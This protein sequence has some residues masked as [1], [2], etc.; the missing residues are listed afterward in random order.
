M[1]RPNLKSNFRF[2]KRFAEDFKKI[3][4][5]TQTEV[6]DVFNQYFPEC[7]SISDRLS[8]AV[9][10]FTESK[11][12]T[13]SKNN[14]RLDLRALP[15]ITHLLYNYNN[16]DKERF[17]LHDPALSI[18][19]VKACCFHYFFQRSLFSNGEKNKFYKRTYEQK[20]SALYLV[21]NAFHALSM[22]GGMEFVE[23]EF[24]FVMSMELEDL[25]KND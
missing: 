14:G 23:K 17:L 24:D 9:S 18:L 25:D 19:L 6:S 4:A 2:L 11:M 1:Y 7:A 5:K 10:L 8:W 15:T 20:V 22:I 21:L 13:N 12:K 16:D 3:S